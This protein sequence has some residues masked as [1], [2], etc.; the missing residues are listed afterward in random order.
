MQQLF[1]MPG[2]LSFIGSGEGVVVDSDREILLPSNLPQ[3]HIVEDIE[4]GC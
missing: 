4:H 3:P 1:D 2:H